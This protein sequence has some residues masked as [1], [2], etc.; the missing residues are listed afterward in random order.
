MAV[1]DSEGEA[2]GDGPSRDLNGLKHLHELVTAI[3][4][5]QDVNRFNEKGRNN[6]IQRLFLKI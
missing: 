4:V 5:K 3:S 1:V 2:S 6:T